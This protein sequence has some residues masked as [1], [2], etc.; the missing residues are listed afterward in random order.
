MASTFHLEVVSVDGQEYSGDVQRITLRSTSGNI[1]ILAHHMNYC[2]A[3]GMGTARIILAD[4]TERSAACI[5]GMLSVMNNICRVLPTTWEWSEEIDVD[6]AQRARARAE[7]RLADSS[8]ST[9]ERAHQEA[10]LYRAL[11]RLQSADR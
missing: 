4:G 9:A 1:A 10:R 7:E 2:T 11:V 5:G 8:L 6:R 3:I